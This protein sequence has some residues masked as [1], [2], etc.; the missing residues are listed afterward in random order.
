MIEPHSP[1]EQPAVYITCFNA[2]V[3]EPLGRDAIFFFD[4]SDDTDDTAEFG[5]D[6]A[7]N[8]TLRI[9]YGSQGSFD[10]C[11]RLI[12]FGDDIP[13]ENERIVA[14]IRSLYPYDTVDYRGYPERLTVTIID[15]DGKAKIAVVC[16]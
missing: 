4:D 3:P 8:E 16:M 10:L 14:I 11:V 6:Y 5:V 7:A 1:N 12:V 13:E 9:P 2:F 15:N